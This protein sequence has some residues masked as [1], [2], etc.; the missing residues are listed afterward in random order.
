MGENM[1]ISLTLLI[2]NTTLRYFPIYVCILHVFCLQ[3][4]VQ[5]Y[6]VPFTGLAN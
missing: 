2:Q 1:E 5:S 4:S 6:M 3:L